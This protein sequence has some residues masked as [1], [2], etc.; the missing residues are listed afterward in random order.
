MSVRRQTHPALDPDPR[1]AVAGD[2]DDPGAVRWRERA[3]FA[4]G[5]ISA[6]LVWTTISSYLLFFYTDVALIGAAA[7]GTLML[8]ARLLD[9]VFDP[10]VGLLLDRTT[11]RWGRARP[12]LLFG[13]PVLAV[14]TVLTFLTPGGGG[15]A[16]LA[17]AYVTFILVGLAYSLVNVPYGAVLA[18]ATR[19]SAT[20]M[21]LA[22]YRGLGIGLGIVLVSSLTGPLVTAI[23]GSP[24]SR[25]GFAWTIGL[26]AVASAVLMWVVFAS[27]RERVPLSPIAGR[28]GTRSALKTL[29]RN[30]PWLSVFVFSILSFARLGIV[31][32]GAIFFALHVLHDPGAI[33]VVLLAFSLSAVA[34]SLVTAPLLRVLGQRRGIVLGLAVSIVCT[35]PLFLLREN[36]AAFAVVFFFA[37]LVGGLGFVAGPAMTADTVEWQE[38]RGGSRNEGLLFAGYSMSTKIGAALGSALLA[39]GL[40]WIGYSPAAVDPAVADGILWL[41]LVLPAAVSVLQVLALAPY[42]LERRLPMV[43]AELRARAGDA[44]PV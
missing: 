16:A 41:F 5:D 7:A 40:A 18:M 23:G 38:W 26:Y 42:D 3:A 35:V 15:G 32:G 21:K 29:A 37:N 19:D 44:G 14:S 27:V 20:R 1:T 33:A 31:T 25:A 6:N 43:R 30:R 17:Y 22:G 36:L 9:A 28:G 39:W 8:V 34:A 2:A 4:L 13:T 10:L 12:Y 24:S 11:T